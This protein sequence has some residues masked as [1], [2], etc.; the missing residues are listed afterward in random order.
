MKRELWE[1]IV[2]L[3]ESVA[4]IDTGTLGL[5]LTD[6]TFDMPL[7]IVLRKTPVGFKFLADAPE[8]RFPAGLSDQPSRLRITLGEVPS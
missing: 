1:S 3:V 7:N 2:D 5:R 6:V 8:W 4:S